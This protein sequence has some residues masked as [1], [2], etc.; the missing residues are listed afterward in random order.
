MK[1]FR[2]FLLSFLVIALPSI[3]L[4]ALPKSECVKCHEKVT[5][6]IV[7]QFLSGKMGKAGLDC[8]ICH[9][10][11]HNTMDDVAKV[12]LPTPDI[13]V[14]CH[15]QQVDQFRAGKHNLAWIAAS[16]MPMWSHQ[17]PAITGPGYRGCSGCHKIGEKR[18]EEKPNFHYGNAQC[19]AC[20]TRHA[21]SKAEA[22][23]P[24]ACSNCHMG[25]DH[26]QWEMY[27][28]SKHG[29]IWDIEGHKADGRA[30]TCQKCHMSGSSHNVVTPWGFLGLRI[31]AK[32]N[33]LALIE[34]APQLEKQL[35]SLA[36]K[37]PSGNYDGVDDDPQWVFDRAIILQAVGVL[38]DNLQ[39]TQRFVD[40]VVKGRVARGP[41]E[42]NK[43][44]ADMK[45]ICNECHSKDYVTNLF[46][47]SDEVIKESDRLFASAI[48]TVQAL[49]KDGVLKKPTEWEYAPDLLHFYDAK[50]SI[51]QDLYLIFLEY[52]QRAFQG[53]FHISNDYMHWYG[54]APLKE[55]VR[56]IED[57]AARLRAENK[58]M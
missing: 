1:V 49:Y 45:K 19:D 47:A 5:P 41:E 22:Q 48:S 25:F 3:A 23:N 20:H 52:R 56:R 13:C 57:E 4:A 38:D 12:T 58:K 30:P 53:A 9:G 2:L 36:E 8:S 51:E 32:E 34:V 35:R 37:L 43:T 42:F 33:V 15:Q 16:S 44:R 31:P 54:W 21:F 40:L 14:T 27:K 46:N 29:I 28:S 6:G 50:S 11:N 7:K 24:M 39:P 55:T 10:K 17:P 26:P 18:A